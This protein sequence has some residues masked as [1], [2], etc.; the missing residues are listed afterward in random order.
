MFVAK[1]SSLSGTLPTALT[2]RLI[3]AVRFALTQSS[4]FLIPV[5]GMNTTAYTAR[6][7]LVTVNHRMHRQ[8]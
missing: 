5:G 8:Q 7:L 3:E 6:R 4:S 2:I 1:L